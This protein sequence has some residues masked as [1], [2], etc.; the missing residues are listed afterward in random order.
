MKLL[1]LFFVSRGH[2]L[3]KLMTRHVAQGDREDRAT[4]R[5]M[6]NAD[7]YDACKESKKVV[8]IFCENVIIHQ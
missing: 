1:Y 2:K 3:A 5:A 7:V 8:R 6:V 4:G